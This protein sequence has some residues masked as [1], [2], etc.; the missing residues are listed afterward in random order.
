[1]SVLYRLLDAVKTDLSALLP[2]TG[3]P[4]SR[5]AGLRLLLY[6]A[7]L[8]YIIRVFFLF[9]TMVPGSPFGEN[10]PGYRFQNRQEKSIEPDGES[11]RQDYGP[12]VTDPGAI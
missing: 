11:N 8:V 1:M 12:T 3:V 2:G 5:Q 9:L 10:D 7:L 4:L 6:L